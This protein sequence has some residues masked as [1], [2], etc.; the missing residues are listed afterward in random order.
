M[1]VCETK[2][3][4]FFQ[5]VI[6]LLRLLVNVPSPSFPEVELLA[7]CAVRNQEMRKEWEDGDWVGEE[8]DQSQPEPSFTVSE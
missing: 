5:K 2:L 4:T 8:G 7:R 1:S 6:S 3:D